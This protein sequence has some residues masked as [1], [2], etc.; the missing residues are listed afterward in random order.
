MTLA[1]RDMYNGKAKRYITNILLSIGGKMPKTISM[2]Q[3]REW[4][5]R[6]ES[7]VTET[8]LAS[9]AKRDIR[10]IKKGLDD[11][12]RERVASRARAELVKEAMRD[13]N[14]QLL[15]TINELIAAL[16]VPSPGETLPWDQQF[17]SGSI[18]LAGMTATYENLVSPNAVTIILDVEGKEEW[19]LL[20]E[21]LRRDKMWP[22]LNQWKKTVAV[23]LEARIRLKQLF[24]KTLEKQTG[25]KII[26]DA[27]SGSFIYS[28]SMGA[29]FHDVLEHLISPTAGITFEDN[30]QIDKEGDVVRYRSS[31]ILARVRGKEEE[32]RN[33]ILGV[34]KQALGSNQAREVIATYKDADDLTSKLRKTVSEFSLLGLVPGQCRICSRLGL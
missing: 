12:R 18:K 28:L 15:N 17:T 11:A 22:L 31:F 26:K 29:V 24:A 5:E 20:K 3:K 14:K 19:D 30:I 6:F 33:Q 34:I 32:C 1:S 8:Q 4:L 9:R 16:K 25:C 23:L 7:G 21:H 10:T 2:A 27:A 13:H